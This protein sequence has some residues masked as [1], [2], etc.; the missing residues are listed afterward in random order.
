MRAESLSTPEHREVAKLLLQKG[1]FEGLDVK[2]PEPLRPQLLQ[3]LSPNVLSIADRY[4][5]GLQ[6]RTW[7]IPRVVPSANPTSPSV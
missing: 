4:P 7:V 1:P 3:S 2:L 6:G 5:E